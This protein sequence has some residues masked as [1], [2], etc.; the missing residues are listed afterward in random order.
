MPAQER[1]SSE[2]RTCTCR[3]SGT[4]VILE[5][6]LLRSPLAGLMLRFIQGNPYGWLIILGAF[7]LAGWMVRS[8]AASTVSIQMQYLGLG[9][10]VLAEAVIFI[11]ILYLAVFYSSP[12]VLPNAAPDRSALRWPDRGRVHDANGLLVPP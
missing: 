6:L 5:V 10:Y 9:L 4:F 7:I 11:P 1:L 8:L 2:V 12:Q 3:C